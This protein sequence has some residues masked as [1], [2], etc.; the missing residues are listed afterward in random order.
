MMMHPHPFFPHSELM[1][2][3]G[4]LKKKKEN[5]K[6][7]VSPMPLHNSTTTEEQQHTAPIYFLTWCYT[8]ISF[9]NTW[10]FIPCNIL[11]F[12]I[13]FGVLVSYMSLYNLEFKDAPEHQQC[14]LFLPWSLCVGFWHLS[15][16]TCTT[17]GQ[18]F[19]LWQSPKRCILLFL[20]SSIPPLQ[21]RQLKFKI[22]LWLKFNLCPLS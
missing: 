6:N 13:D 11:Y 8:A 20:F 4:C 18:T 5:H 21:K 15:C 3:Q 14:Q 12:N 10:H 7:H 17:R 1:P 2:V 19:I 16:G 9:L 22:W